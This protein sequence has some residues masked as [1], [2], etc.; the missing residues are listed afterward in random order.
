MRNSYLGLLVG[1]LSML[2]AGLA[3]CQLMGGGGSQLAKVS[4]TVFGAVEVEVDV[5]I[6]VEDGVVEDWLEHP[7][8]IPPIITTIASIISKILV[9]ACSSRCS[10]FFQAGLL[11]IIP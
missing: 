2:V 5:V 10:N 4:L 11:F 8:N 1:L 6:A 7:A 3:G 9:I